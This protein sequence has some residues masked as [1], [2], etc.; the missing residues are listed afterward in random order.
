MEHQVAQGLQQ[1]EQIAWWTLGVI[2][3]SILAVTGF[4]LGMAYKGIVKKLDS[5]EESI[6][7]ISK[8]MS[9]QKEKNDVFQKTKDRIDVLEDKVLVIET[10]HGACPIIIKQIPGAG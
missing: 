4:M 8:F 6:K 5:L 3:F 2:V 9:A 1:T 7:E 10:H